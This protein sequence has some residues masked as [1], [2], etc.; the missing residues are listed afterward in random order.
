MPKDQHRYRWEDFSDLV[1]NAFGPCKE[2]RYNPDEEVLEGRVNMEG[3]F[4]IKD[5]T[6]F[7]DVNLLK[8]PINAQAATYYDLE[9]NNPKAIVAKF[10][11]VNISTIPA[12][13]MTCMCCLDDF[14]EA[15]D[16][17]SG[18]DESDED[19]SDNYWVPYQDYAYE[20]AFNG[21]PVPY[22]AID[23]DE[24]YDD[25]SDDDDSEDDEA[26]FFGPPVL[27]R[28]QPIDLA[29]DEAENDEAKPHEIKLSN[30]KVRFNN[31]PVK[32]PCPHGHL[33]GKTCLL[34]LLDAEMRTCPMCRFVIY[35]P[36]PDPRRDDHPGL[37]VGVN[38]DQ[39]IEQYSVW[40]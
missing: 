20:Y 38:A 8:L 23:W 15:E 34:Q 9:F 36:K 29:D 26:E 6:R 10:E 19:K 18:D 17:E 12:E 39:V 13:K 1:S 2:E 16:N 24:L 22:Q 32:M 14:E 31:S 7:R 27:I 40:D 21:F 30:G 25:D 37:P 28:Y 35:T 3:A 11:R 33:I 5:L 4:E